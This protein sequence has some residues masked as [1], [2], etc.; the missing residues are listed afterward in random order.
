MRR[1]TSLFLLCLALAGLLAACG[2]GGGGDTGNGTEP[3]P[4]IDPPVVTDQPEDQSIL[5]G[6]STVFDVLATGDGTLT[7]QWQLSE[8]GGSTWT[9]LS[10]ETGT[11]YSTPAAALSDD[12]NQYRCVVTN[13]G[14]STASAA[15]TLTVE[16]P[17]PYSHTIH[18]DG[19][20]EFTA[21]ETF[22]ST[23]PGHRGYVTWD[24]DFVYVGLDSSAVG[25]ASASD[26][27]LVYV[28]GASGTLNG[29]TYGSQQPA[30]PFSARYHVR[31]RMDN[32]VLQTLQWDGA[33]WSNANW[34]FTGDSAFLGNFFEMRLPRI[35]L[36]DP[37]TL[38][39]HLC[40]VHDAGNPV[41]DWTHTG[42]PDTSFA[43][44]LDPDY[45]AWYEFDLL[46][47][48]PPAFYPP[49]P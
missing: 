16:S 31:W 40:V 6:D 21:E 11:T 34:D 42:V 17:P 13:A 30:L 7:Y 27:F 19:G 8:N 45:T 36:G 47:Q 32:S 18:M 44:G 41:Q 37:T 43:D 4:A 23:S 12:G 1:T 20:N 10:G 35:D 24:A 2:G 25:G 5:V 28:G 46:G 29:V 26:V 48:D 33:N 14:G 3:P 38:Q 49:K 22:D 39:I 15:A 9:D